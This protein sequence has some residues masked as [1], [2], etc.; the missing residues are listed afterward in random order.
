MITGLLNDAGWDVNHK[1]VE[2]L[3]RR[4]ELK[5]PQK[6]AK[7]GRLWPGDGFCVR[8]RPECPNHVWSDDFVHDRTQDGDCS[9]RSTTSQDHHGDRLL[10]ELQCPVSRRVSERRDFLLPRRSP[11]PHRV[12]APPRQYYQ[13]R[14]FARIPPAPCRSLR[15][16]R[17]AS[18]NAIATKLDHSMG[19]VHACLLE[20]KTRPPRGS[21][22]PR[23]SVRTPR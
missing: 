22:C 2:R 21:T 5:F 19:A 4:E 6:Q 1:R 17:S 16:K 9:G 18:N 12:M 15:V 7:K 20:V 8:L 23:A 11:G 10:R 14:Q 3:W 13:A